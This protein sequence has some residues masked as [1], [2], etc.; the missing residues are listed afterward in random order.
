MDNCGFPLHGSPAVA[1]LERLIR[2]GK[3][4][5]YR[6]VLGTWELSM[7]G[8]GLGREVRHEGLSGR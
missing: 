8:V 6:S 3:S 7:V 4:S 2:V 1:H 5:L